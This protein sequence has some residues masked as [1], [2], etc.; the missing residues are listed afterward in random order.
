MSTDRIPAT[1]PHTVSTVPTY[2]G[3]LRTGMF[4]AEFSSGATVQ[5]FVSRARAYPGLNSSAPST[6][7]FYAAVEDL[8]VRG[9]V[10]DAG[11]GA[12]AAGAAAAA[13]AG[14]AG[15]C[16]G[17]WPGPIRRDRLMT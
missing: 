16:P 17:D 4:T 2:A 15:A 3:D 11:A 5:V 9:P 12:G 10:L 8:N 6:V 7:P 1:A 13:T 14:A